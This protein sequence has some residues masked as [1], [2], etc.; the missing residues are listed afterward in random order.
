MHVGIHRAK[1]S[2]D[3]LDECQW[4]LGFLRQRQVSRDP[5]VRENM[6]E[7]LVDLLQDA[8]DYS[9]PVAKGAHFVL[10]HRI[11]DGLASWE[12]LASVQKI[13]ERFSKP[14]SQHSQNFQN[15][16]SDNRFS[17]K[18]EPKPVRVSN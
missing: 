12:D 5:V 17:K 2:Y 10:I 9:W 18:K 14:H 7:Y 3:Q 4:L 15:H 16:V 6:V 13:R 8:V 11:I 1:P